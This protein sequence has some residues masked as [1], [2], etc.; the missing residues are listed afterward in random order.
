[1]GQSIATDVN[2][3]L[4]A[5]VGGLRAATGVGAYTTAASNHIVNAGSGAGMNDKLPVRVQSPSETGSMV[6]SHTEFVSNI[7]A[8]DSSGFSK[9]EYLI[10][11]G[12]E[13]TFKWLA[14]IAGQ[15]KEYELV[16]CI[17]SFKST[18]SDFQTSHG[19]V[20]TI[21]MASEYNVG[22]KTAVYDTKQELMADVS[23]VSAKVTNGLCFGIECDPA[24]LKGGGM[25]KLVK[26][27]RTKGLRTHQDQEDFDWC[28]LTVATSDVPQ[29]LFNRCLGELHVTY[30]VKL[31]RPSIKGLKGGNISQS[32]WARDDAFSPLKDFTS[33]NGLPLDVSTNSLCVSTANAI[34]VLL[35]E[36]PAAPFTVPLGVSGTLGSGKQTR[37]VAMYFPAQFEGNIKVKLA[38]HVDD[39]MQCKA[40]ACLTIPDSQITPI[41]DINLGLINGSVPG[42]GIYN[43]HDSIIFDRDASSTTLSSQVFVEVHLKI[44]E[45]TSG[46]DNKICFVFEADKNSGASAEAKI[47]NQYLVVEEYNADVNEEQT[48]RP[49]WVNLNSGDVIVT[50]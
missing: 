11:P 1:V 29:E 49:E 20:G 46:V 10:N 32:L 45:S 18:V 40:V 27:I 7:Y 14:S 43:Q 24:K 37:T 6:V 2:P 34:D 15:Y 19:V 4:G 8:P 42:A 39:D 5:A 9:Q 35:K 12:L 16:Q 47:R 17:F 28:R 23:A 3:L 48:D 38:L 50:N 21:S 44:Q 36:E 41:K 25:E 33:A 22:D 13:S 30:T 31:N 26:Y